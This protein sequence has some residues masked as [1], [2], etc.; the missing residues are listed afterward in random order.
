MKIRMKYEDNAVDRTVDSAVEEIV[1]NAAVNID[2]SIIIKK[3]A[4]KFTTPVDLSSKSNVLNF[5]TQGEVTM[6]LVEPNNI[7]E[8]KN[9]MKNGFNEM[10]EKQLLQIGSVLDFS[11]QYTETGGFFSIFE[12]AFRFYHDRECYGTVDVSFASDVKPAQAAEIAV[13]F[14]RIADLLKI[15][16]YI[17]EE[18]ERDE[19]DLGQPPHFEDYGDELN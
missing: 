18:H 10:F 12:D 17:E 5:G 9:S 19:S 3:N 6:E 11:I 13:K 15:T 1:G 2:D 4:E 7:Y 8:W 14:F 16:V